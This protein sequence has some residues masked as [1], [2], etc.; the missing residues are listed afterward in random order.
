MG[1]L[2]HLVIKLCAEHVGPD[3]AR[4]ETEA[5]GNTVLSLL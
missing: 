5:E 4:A 3:V 2:L 1:I